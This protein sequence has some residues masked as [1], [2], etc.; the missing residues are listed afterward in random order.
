M[1]IKG[2]FL[3]VETTFF[4]TDKILRSIKMPINYTDWHLLR[5]ENEGYTPEELEFNKLDYQVYCAK[6]NLKSNIHKTVELLNLYG[7]N[8]KEIEEFVNKKL[9]L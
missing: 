9:N 5:L 6:R 1:E 4:E 8:K 3:K 2:L 7:I